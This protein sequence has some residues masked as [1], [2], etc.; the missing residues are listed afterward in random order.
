MINNE[1]CRLSA[2]RESVCGT[3]D[4]VFT[5]GL[6]RIARSSPAEA[7]RISL[8]FRASTA[9]EHIESIA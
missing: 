5:L 4:I 7:G 1:F 3:G 9:N 8:I 6:G 2:A